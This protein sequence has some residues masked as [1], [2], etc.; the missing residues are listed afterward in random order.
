MNQQLP[1]GFYL[2]LKLPAT[3]QNSIQQ[4]QIQLKLNKLFKQDRLR[5]VN[6]SPVLGWDYWSKGGSFIYVN[7]RRKCL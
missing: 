7:E 6:P 2:K 5:P 4:V 3:E 1:A